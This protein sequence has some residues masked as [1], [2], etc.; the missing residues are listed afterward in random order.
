MNDNV[1]ALPWDYFLT[2]YER[3]LL[4][5]TTEDALSKYPEMSRSDL[6]KQKA[7]LQENQAVF[8]TEMDKIA[9][10]CENVLKIHSS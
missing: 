3:D 4:N 8:T 10:A 7:I 9:P 6:E 2:N 1:E 5:L